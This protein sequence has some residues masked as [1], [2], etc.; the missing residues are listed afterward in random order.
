MSFEKVVSDRGL[1][2]P[3][4]SSAGGNYIPAKTVGSL[5]YLSGVISKDENGVITGTVGA[6]KTVEDG[7]AAARGC[8]LA[9][10]AVLKKHLG[11]LD[12][13]KQVVSVNGYVN[14]VN[15]FPD[16]PK[17]ING[18]SDLLEEV[19]GES[20]KHVRAAIGVNSLPRNALVE[21]QMV[22]AI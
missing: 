1:V 2:L 5:V 8:A 17:V 10:L 11:S 4:T 7:Y 12:L 9:Q 16:P 19:F 21:V 6:D 22:V 18:F 3:A 14:A 20:G 13:I 15:G